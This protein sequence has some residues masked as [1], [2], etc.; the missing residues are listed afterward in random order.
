MHPWTDFELIDAGEGARLER[1]GDHVVIGPAPG[2]WFDDG[3][4][5]ALGRMPTSAT[6]VTVVGRRRPRAG[7]AVG[8]RSTTCRLELPAPTDAG[9]VGLLPGARGDAPLARRLRAERLPMALPRRV[10]HLFAHTGLTTL[11]MARPGPRSRTSTP[12]I[13][14]SPGLVETPRSMASRIARS[15]GSSTMPAPSW[16]ARAAEIAATTAVVLDPPTY[17]H[18]SSGKA[19]AIGR[20]SRPAARRARRSS[21]RTHSSCSPPTRTLEDQ[22]AGRLGP[23]SAGPAADIEAGDLPLDATSGAHLRLGVFARIDGA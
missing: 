4:P 14:R 12:R 23:R 8:S 3:E 15:A 21:N 5:R 10:L 7:R 18:G 17:G 6:N 22:L 20:R 19:V 11:A 2:A 1:F 13:R 9:Q 16:R